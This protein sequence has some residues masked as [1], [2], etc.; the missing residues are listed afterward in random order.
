MAL[1]IIIWHLHF[2]LCCA[3]KAKGYSCKTKDELLRNERKS[4]ILILGILYIFL[5]FE[6]E[7]R[8]NDD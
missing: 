3:Y 8:K 6:H 1:A 7:V 5:V 2:L 4:A